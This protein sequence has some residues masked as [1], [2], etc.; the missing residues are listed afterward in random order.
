M[1]KEIVIPSGGVKPL[2]PYSPAIRIGKFVYTSGQIGIDPKTGK[3]APGGVTAETRQTLENLSNL[4]IT[5]GASLETAVKVTVYLRDIEDYNLVN[6]VYADFFREMSPA[7]SIVQG[8]L[9]AG[10]MIEIDAIAFVQE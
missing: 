4:L 7:R 1:K 6:E 3:L 8:K 5:A 10:A 9:P 2:A